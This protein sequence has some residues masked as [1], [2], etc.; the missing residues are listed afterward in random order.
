MPD[1]ILPPQVAAAPAPAASGQPAG[2]AR[3]PLRRR[4]FAL[5]FAGQLISGLGD[6]A[7]GIALP[8][9]VLAATGDARQMAVVLA[10]GAVPRML[11]LL[12]GGALADRISPR[13][14][15][16]VTDAGRA[17]VVAAL[18]VTL[19][20]GL[21]PLWV[22]AVLAGLE[23]LGT[24]LFQPSYPSITPALVPES[25]LPA[26]NGMMQIIQFLSMVLGPLLGGVA[27]AAQASIAFLADA[28]TFF[29]SFLTLGAIRMP[30]RTHETARAGGSMAA[31]IGAGLRYSLGHPLLRTTIAVSAL[32][33][34]GLG[35]AASVALI[36]LARN[37]SPSPVTLGILVTVFGVGGLIGGLSAA[38]AGRVRRRGVVIV[39]LLPLIALL[40]AGVALVAGPSASKLAFGISLD[41]SLRI[42]AM[43]GLLGLVGVLIAL[44]DTM[45]VTIMQQKMDPDYLARVF[46][47][48]LL[49][50]GVAQPL[51]LLTAG[52]ATAVYGPGVTFLAGS[53]VFL[54]ASAIAI[55]SREMRQ[56]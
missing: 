48:Q 43:A 39:T 33:N 45:F 31:D 2:R 44:T 23:G 17:V 51:S 55:M 12:I 3:S 47:V 11:A 38:L 42:P 22:V 35:G 54:I 46:S 25:E 49:A 24:G 37:I 34:F 32:G 27:T 56:V 15:M 20:A 13:L 4:N 52:V 8:W 21:P 29:V 40:M 50:G 6:Q 19:F 30:R 9:T 5:L 53:G 1:E 16:L 14:V 26:A 28:V 7:Y 36:V 41:P 10:A 18:G